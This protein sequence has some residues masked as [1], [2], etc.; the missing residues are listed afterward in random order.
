MG[1]LDGKTALVTGAS[2]GIGWAVAQKLA[3]EGAHVHLLS[4]GRSALDDGVSA[5]NAQGFS[6]TGIVGNV[7]EFG[8]VEAAVQAA[9]QSTGRLDIVV[10]NAGVIEPIDRLAE[11]DPSSWSRAID[12]NLK[13]VFNGLR[14]AL[15]PMIAAGSGT[16]INMSS[17]AANSALEGWS[18]YC[19][20]KAAAKKLTEIAHKEY[21]DSGVVITG[22]SPGTVAT[23]M[24]R[25]IKESGVN[26]VS[27]LPWSAHIPAEWVAEAVVYLC[28][29]EGRDY[30]G[31]DFSLKT[32]EGR[33][34][35]GLP[36]TGVL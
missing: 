9:L 12:V 26:P 21:A 1:Q 11:V 31:R 10:N 16:I 29:A 25:S 5:L 20:S 13:G 6:A 2:K 8:D 33:E 4:R 19:A 17:G 15:P 28:G 7:A 35:V 3:A 36:L 27:R 14:A 32:R 24:M 30:A 23:D 22:L 34:A 18:Q